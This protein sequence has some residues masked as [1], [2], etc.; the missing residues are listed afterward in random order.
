MQVM[1]NLI[2]EFKIQ[3][4]MSIWPGNLPHKRAKKK[5]QYAVDHGCLLLDNCVN[6][7]KLLDCPVL[8]LNDIEN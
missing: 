7:P 2:T 1:T 6:C 5:L 8:N 3:Q 4:L